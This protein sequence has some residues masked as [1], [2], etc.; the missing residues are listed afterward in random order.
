MHYVKINQHLFILL[1]KGLRCIQCAIAPFHFGAAKRDL[2]GFARTLTSTSQ[3]RQMK[4]C[5]NKVWWLRFVITTCSDQHLWSHL[6]RTSASDS[7]ILVNYCLGTQGEMPSNLLRSATWRQ[8]PPASLNGPIFGLGKP[9][10]RWRISQVSSKLKTHL[11]LLALDL[12]KSK[13]HN[14]LLSQH[15]AACHS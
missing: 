8:F 3:T 12:D 15:S 5:S 9:N 10:I 7:N 11:T 1:T 6:P 14:S 4:L 13:A 2:S